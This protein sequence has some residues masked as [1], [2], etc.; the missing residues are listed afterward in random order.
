[1]QV[2][3]KKTLT[4]KAGDNVGILL[5]GIKRETVQR[6]MFICKPDSIVQTDA[7]RAQ[8]YVRT[9]AEGGRSKP[10]LTNYINQVTL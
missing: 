5:R 7:F 1:M 4:A 6:G 3:H 2:F 8:L 9:K 10:M